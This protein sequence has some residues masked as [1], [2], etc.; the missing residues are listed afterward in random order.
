MKKKIPLTL[1]KQDTPLTPLKRGIGGIRKEI[2][3]PNPPEA[4]S[5]GNKSVIKIY[6]PDKNCFKFTL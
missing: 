3:P 6:Q 5:G 2:N 4:S 1:P